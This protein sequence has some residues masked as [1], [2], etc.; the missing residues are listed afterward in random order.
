[1]V[2]TSATLPPGTAAELGAPAGSTK[3]LDVGSPFGYDSILK[4]G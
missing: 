4:A 1:M 2:L 3:E